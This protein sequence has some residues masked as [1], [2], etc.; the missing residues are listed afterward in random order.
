MF[1]FLK[2]IVRC[3]FEG[4][5]GIDCIGFGGVFVD[6][7]YS[8]ENTWGGEYLPNITFALFKQICILSQSILAN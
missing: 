2:N 5:V 3:W 6:E 1:Y 4:E 7:I 8:N